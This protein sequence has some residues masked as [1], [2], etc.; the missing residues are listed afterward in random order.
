LPFPMIDH[1]DILKDG[2]SA[3]YGSDAITGVVNFFLIH[4]FRGL[5]IGG[6]YGDTNLGASNDMGEWEAWLKAGTGDDKT[7]IVVIA[8][9]WQRTGGLF[10]A[11]RDLSS[12]GF[13]IP[14]G[15]SDTRNNFEPGAACVRRVLPKMFFGP[16]GTPLPGV[17]TP[18]PHSA[19]NVATAPFYKAP[20]FPFLSLPPPLGPGIPPGDRRT[21]SPNAYPG[22]PG[23][24]GPKAR[25]FFPQFGTDYKGG[26]DYFAYNFA[27]VTPALPP[28]DRQSF[29]GSFTRDLC[30][31][32]LVLF[33]DFKYVRSFF[34]ASLAAVPFQPDPFKIP[35]T[36][37]GFSPGGDS[38]SVPIQNPFNPFTVADATIPNFFPDGSGLPVTTG[39]LFPGVLFR[40]INDTGP[41]HEKFTY[42]D[43]LFDMGL[44]G[45]MGEFCDYFK[46][47]NWELGFRYSRN[48]GQNLSV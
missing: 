41:R 26:G 25:F 38:I 40:G 46:T 19:P 33:A 29:Y 43:S 28:A 48:E 10:S 31:K 34:D 23:V 27:A 15:G 45:E 3:V 30:D 21:I 35:G 32:Y 17:N 4:K 47:W 16:G 1:I 36:N 24:I 8:D 44:R 7:D 18:L 13:Q 20:Y 22:A 5:E 11:D 12:N 9:F 39:V 6:S 37:I 14:W 42:W 2:A